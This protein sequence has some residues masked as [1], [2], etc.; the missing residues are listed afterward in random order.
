MLSR[1]A[2]R[3]YWLSRYMERTGNTAKTVYAYASLFLD[4][5]AGTGTGWHTLIEINDAEE[6]FAELYDKKTEDNIM[7][8]LIFDERNPA[9]MYSSICFARENA[10]TSRDILPSEVWEIINGLY[11]TAKAEKSEK[12][13]RS[14]RYSYLNSVTNN[15]MRLEGMFNS[16]LS[17]NN[18]YSFIELGRNIERADTTTRILDVGS[19]LLVEG[20]TEFMIGHQGVIWMNL[21]RSMNA[22]QM[23]RQEVKRKVVGEDVVKFLLFNDEF[24]RSVAFCIDQI[25]KFSA[26]LPN[27]DKIIEMSNRIKFG[28]ESFSTEN[29]TA[30]RII[31]HMD[32][33]QKL[34]AE[35]HNGIDESW[36]NTSIDI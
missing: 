1:I 4:L 31:K 6:L 21:L 5:P 27:S 15:V 28:L 24:P 32:E 33:I 16:G 14:R 34:L 23:Y 9:S 17:R 25:M 2:N 11:L 22:Y 8:F 13:S 10:R 18:T 26:K 20:K 30:E 7:N 36:F 19:T 3:V 35:L 29:V 12:I